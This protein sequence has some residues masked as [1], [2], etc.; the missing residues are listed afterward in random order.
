[1]WGDFEIRQ[2]CCVPHPM[3]NFHAG[4]NASRHV[5]HGFIV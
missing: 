3:Q 4:S 5:E 1:V 2:P